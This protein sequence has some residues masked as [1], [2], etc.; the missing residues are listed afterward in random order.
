MAEKIR[1]L[2]GTNDEKAKKSATSDQVTAQPPDNSNLI[3]VDDSQNAEFVDSEET[4]SDGSPINIFSSI[5]NG[6]ILPTEPTFS[7]VIK[8]LFAYAR[9][10]DLDYGASS[11]CGVVLIVF[12]AMLLWAFAS[13]LLDNGNIRAAILLGMSL[14]ALTTI[15]FWQENRRLWSRNRREAL[16]L[17]KFTQEKGL[18]YLAAVQVLPNFISTANSHLDD[19]ERRF[20]RDA[21]GD[22]DESIQEAIA[23]LDALRPALE[24]IVAT[25]CS[26]STQLVSREH[27]F[28]SL[29]SYFGQIPDPTATL[30]QVA[31]SLRLFLK[32]TELQLDHS[33]HEY[34][35]NAF[36]PFWDSVEDA[37]R[38]LNEFRKSAVSV[39][40]IQKHFFKATSNGSR[41]FP[42]VP[43][44][45][46]RVP[47]PLPTLQRLDEIVRLGQTNFQFA[48]IWEQRKI[49]EALLEGFGTWADAVGQIRA[50][51]VSAIA[52]VG[53]RA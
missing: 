30:H 21:F 44:R 37:V 2:F 53:Y 36:G 50:H 32:L 42:L 24:G 34:Q 43:D 27:T 13:V 31:G 6:E 1:G 12:C 18:S 35:A 3:R 5:V 40:A 16:H 33:H 22:W 17:T 29:P 11:G 47:D 8:K 10:S 48:T 41:L 20:E 45:V 15:A 23:S 19:A 26:Y 4:I 51:V 7:D 9:P 14:I 52:S 46:D 38:A 28:P 39:G 25:H 49:R